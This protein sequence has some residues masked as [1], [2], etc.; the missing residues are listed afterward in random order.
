MAGQIDVKGFNGNREGAPEKRLVR[1]QGGF[2][3][4]E[5]L[6]VRI[7][8]DCWAN[9]ASKGAL[10]HRGDILWL[11]GSYIRGETMGAEENVKLLPMSKHIQS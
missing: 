11:Q 6:C 9:A 8:I 2:E 4:I 7:G 3:G 5:G 10:F 1:C